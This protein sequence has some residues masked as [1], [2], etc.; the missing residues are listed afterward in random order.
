M[1]G[2]IRVLVVDDHPIVRK[3]IRH[4]LETEPEIEMVGEAANGREAVRKFVD[5]K[6]D[7]VLLDLVMPELDG[8]GAILA[9]KLAAD[10]ARIL[11]LTTFASDDKLFPAI[12]AGALGYL[13]KDTEPEELVQAIKRAHS[14]EISLSPAIAQKVLN[15]ISGS[16]DRPLTADPLTGREVE[17]LG[18]LAKGLANRQIAEQLVISEATVRTHVGNILGKLHLASRT[19]AALYALR[20][21]LASLY[22]TD[23]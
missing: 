21:G 8:I 11:V 13:L 2:R 9:I 5:V 23:E 3:G 18:L 15:E 1:T 14:G 19:Q 22:G 17:V 20:E 4:L 10:H 16:P 6:P 7:V 12:R